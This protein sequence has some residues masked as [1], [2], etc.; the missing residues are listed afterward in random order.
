MDITN[1]IQW[2][3]EKQANAQRKEETIKFVEEIITK[4]PDLEKAKV[5]KELFKELIHKQARKDKFNVVEPPLSFCG[6]MSLEIF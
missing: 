1:Q 6:S 4:D 5:M 3:N 2:L